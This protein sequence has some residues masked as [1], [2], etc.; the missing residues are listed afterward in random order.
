[1]FFAPFE[2]RGNVNEFDNRGEIVQISPTI[3][4]FP[5]IIQK[6]R[7]KGSQKGASNSI[8]I[9]GYFFALSES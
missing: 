1:M 4:N 2:P 7:E 6:N 8:Y 9:E 3:V 5:K